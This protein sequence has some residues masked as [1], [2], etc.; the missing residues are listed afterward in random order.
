MEVN[1]I[2]VLVA[3]LYFGVLIAIGYM[4][5]KAAT[6]PM[7]YYVAGRKVGSVVNGAALAA[8]YFS[9]A[10]FLG[11]PAFIF[12]LGYPF[13]WVLTAIIAGLPLASMLTA[14]PLRKYAPISFT[15]Y[16]ADRYESPKVMRILSGLPTL[17]SGWAYVVLSLVGT[18]LFMMAILRIPYTWS[19]VIAALVTLFYVFLGGMVATTFSTA[20]QGVLMAIASVVV[21]FAIL[22]HFGGFAGLSEAVYANNPNFWLVPH[23]DP[24]GAYSHPLMSYWTG[25]VGFYF[26]WHYGFSVMPYTVVRFFTSMDIKSARR[27][28]FWAVIFGGTMYWGLIIAGTAARVILETMHPLM[29]QGAENAVGVLVMIQDAFGVGGAAITDYS[30]IAL[31]EALGNP[32]LMGILVAGGLAISMATGATWVMV[33]NVLIGRDWMGKVFGNKWAIENPVASLKVWT[34]IIMII[35]TLFAFNPMAL[36]LDLSGWAFIVVIA[37]TGMPLVF[38][39]W[40]RRATTAAA[41]STIAV[42]FPLSLYTWLY[43]K[44]VLGSAH[45]FF[46]S[47]WIWGEGG[48][49]LPTGHQVWLIPVSAVFFIVVSLLTKPNSEETLKKYCDDLH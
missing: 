9:P 24:G 32:L 14:A 36:V 7:D 22:G 33:L 34:V 8:A 4:T 16:F 10:S 1:P 23:A 3:V 2:V 49:M 35:G 38:G 46:A 5:R 41:I 18:A 43:A 25:M 15:D 39:L 6:D 31:V 44:D 42:F 40:W 13:W 30:Y 27:S 29:D 11:M 47:R 17:M 48:F 21:G 19:V 20:F 28:V 45:W 26:V 12:I 37:T